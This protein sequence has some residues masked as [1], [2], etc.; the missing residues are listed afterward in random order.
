MTD[1]EI[2]DNGGNIIAQSKGSYEIPYIV[3]LVSLLLLLGLAD[4]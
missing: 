2:F 3:S 4:S 1:I